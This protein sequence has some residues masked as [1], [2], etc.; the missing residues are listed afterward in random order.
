MIILVIHMNGKN[1]CL[2][3]LT[4]K[5]LKLMNT[6]LLN[7]TSSKRKRITSEGHP[8]SQFLCIKELK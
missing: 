3:S 7:A 6:L 1:L 5:I 2:C 8:Y 4:I